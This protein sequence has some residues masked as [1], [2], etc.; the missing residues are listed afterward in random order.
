M[1]MVTLNFQAITHNIKDLKQCD[2]N[3]HRKEIYL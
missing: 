1:N 2:K 3:V